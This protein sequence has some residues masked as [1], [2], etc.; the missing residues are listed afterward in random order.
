MMRNVITLSD[1]PKDLHDW[2]K[3]E[4]YR[5]S[6]LKGRRIGIYQL[7]VQAVQEYRRN[8]EKNTGDPQ[9][10]GNGTV[11]EVFRKKLQPAEV[12]RHCVCVPKEKWHFFGQT[13]NTITMKDAGGGYTY[14]VWIGS[15]YRLSM[16]DW[17]NRHN[18]VRPGD[19]VI[20]VQLNGV[21]SVQLVAT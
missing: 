17:Y 7:V 18:G 20:F 11:V 2:L 14:S 3:N 12:K 16:G 1:M 21:I 5:Q 4:A 9:N 10:L 13:G 15:Q 8:V 19:E 6:R